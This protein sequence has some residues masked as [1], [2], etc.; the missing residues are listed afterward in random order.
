MKKE[1]FVVFGI[2]KNQQEVENAIESLDKDGFEL[3]DISVIH[4]Y[5]NELKNLTEAFPMNVQL[6]A[7]TGAETGAFVGGTLGMLIGMGTLMIPGLGPLIV[8][9]PVIATIAGASFGGAVGG[10]SGA[11]VGIGV[12]QHAANIYETSIQNGETLVSVHTH[13]SAWS[14]LAE[15]ALEST[16]ARSISKTETSGGHWQ[17]APFQHRSTEASKAKS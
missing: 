12:P 6:G 17:I 9:G 16:G 2:Y 10:L 15:L 1:G 5:T 3:E 11:L 14:D 4:P 8:L 13:D 7:V